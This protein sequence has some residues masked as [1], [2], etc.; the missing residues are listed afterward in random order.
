MII[1]SSNRTKGTAFHKCDQFWKHFG[2]YRCYKGN[3]NPLSLHR[4]FFNISEIIVIFQYSYCSSV[5]VVFNNCHPNN[6][7]FS[8][9]LSACFLC[10]SSFFIYVSYYYCYC[11]SSDRYWLYKTWVGTLRWFSLLGAPYF[12]WKRLDLTAKLPSPLI[13]PKKSK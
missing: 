4:L 10:I 6:G 3:S 11:Y 7:F 8:F 1:C 5:V 9:F 13:L 2:W 12:H